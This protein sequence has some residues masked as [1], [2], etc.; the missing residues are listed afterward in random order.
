MFLNSLLFARVLPEREARR[1][2][3]ERR[4]LRYKFKVHTE[5]LCHSFKSV[6]FVWDIY[7]LPVDSCAQGDPGAVG[8]AGKTGPVGPQ[9][10]PG[11]PGTEG[12]RG[13]PGSVV[14]KNSNMLISFM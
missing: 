9:G 6:L 2:V 3:R 8:P 13:L 7:S 11:K 4:E 12:L 5:Y 14:S 10:Q 1:D